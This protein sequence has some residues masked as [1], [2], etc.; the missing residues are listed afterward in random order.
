MSG[1]AI[2]VILVVM[3][4]FA[5]YLSA[6]PNS[7]Y[8]IYEDDYRKKNSYFRNK[9]NQRLPLIFKRKEVELPE[10]KEDVECPVNIVVEK[11]DEPEIK[12]ELK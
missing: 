3:V 6:A 2:F 5:G 4:A 9:K 12:V 7:N 8:T 10:V 1:Y 11:P